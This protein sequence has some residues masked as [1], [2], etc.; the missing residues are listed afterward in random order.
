MWLPIW[1]LLLVCIIANAL[2][3]QAS[4]GHGSKCSE[5]NQSRRKADRSIVDLGHPQYLAQR[6]AGLPKWLPSDVRVTLHIT[7]VT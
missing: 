4:E 1:R 7:P 5:S 3:Q 6:E 2:P